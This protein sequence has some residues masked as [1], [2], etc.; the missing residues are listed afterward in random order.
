VREAGFVVRKEAEELGGCERFRA[1]TALYS[2]LNYVWQGDT[3][4]S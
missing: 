4:P 2:S 1:H 3:P